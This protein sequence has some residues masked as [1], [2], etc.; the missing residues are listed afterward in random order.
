MLL[1]TAAC[2]AYSNAKITPI[3]RL[4][5]K[6]LETADGAVILLLD[7]WCVSQCYAR[8]EIV[9]VARESPIVDG[10]LHQSRAASLAP[11][12]FARP[13]R[14]RTDSSFESPRVSNQIYDGRNAIAIPATKRQ[15]TDR[16]D[17]EREIDPDTPLQSREKEVALTEEVQPLN[18]PRVSSPF[19][20]A[21]SQRSPNGIRK[22]HPNHIRLLLL[23]TDLQF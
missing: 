21:D 23:T 20:V 5:I 4:E 14:R 10:H 15:K 1:L 7:E 16:K 6:H 9:R 12:S 8:N 13:K 11:G 3:L 18:A 22:L 19:V 2:V 17:T